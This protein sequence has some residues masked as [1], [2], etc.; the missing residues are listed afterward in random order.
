[1]PVSLF[2]F[3]YIHPKLDFNLFLVLF[4]WHV[5]VFP[6]SNGYNSYNDR[7]EGPIGGLAAPPKPT[8]TLLNLC[9]VMDGMAIALSLMINYYFFIFVAI[10]IIFSR[11]YSSR[12]I[13]LKKFPV[14][15]FLVVF[16][17]QGAWIFYA[18][19]FAFYSFNLLFN[20][21]VIFSAIAS[22]FFIG[23]IYPLT[24]IYQHDADRKDGVNTL[25]MLLGI[26]GTFIFSAIS[27][28]LATIF[29]YLSFVDTISTF[30]LFNLIMFPATLF[31]LIWAFRS[32]KNSSLVN[33]K[34]TMIMLVLS[35][36]LNNL[37]FII[38]LLK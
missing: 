32:F 1:L 29:V 2:A 7:D 20:P 24:Q 19:L 4:I 21:A 33:F 26:K 23:T 27:F 28:S 25:S 31:F 16:V 36:F 3:F 18:N 10:Y 37:F 6:A 8:K 9:N 5:L 17:F 38:L 11:L 15:G 34:N 12:S 35:S 13:R 22:S 14:I 30:F